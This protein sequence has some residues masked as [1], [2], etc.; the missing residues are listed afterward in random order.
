MK[1]KD[2]TEDR[3]DN[4]PSPDVPSPLPV[5]PPAE[6]GKILDLIDEIESE[7][8]TKVYSEKFG[9]FDPKK[10]MQW[11]DA[12]RM[13]R[14]QVGKIMNVPIN[15]LTGIEPN[16]YGDHLVKLARGE[17]P[18]GPDKLPVIYV[19]S[20][21]AYVGDGNHR[22]VDEFS[23]GNKTVKALVLDF[24]QQEKELQQ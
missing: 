20:T 24:R 8:I 3:W 7:Y 9:E 12:S 11:G 10:P 23:R 15:K 21:G 18:K 14:Q 22:V 4:E 1:L 2:I 17:A 19:L 13:V 16:L 6:L 5:P